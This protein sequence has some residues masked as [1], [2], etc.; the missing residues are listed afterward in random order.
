MEDLMSLE[1]VSSDFHLGDLRR[2]YDN[3]EASIRAL[4]ALGVAVETYGAL[5]TP[6]FMKKIPQDSRLTITRRVNSSDWNMKKIL[7]VFLEELEARERAIL[8][9]IRCDQPSQ[10]HHQRNFDRHPHLKSL[11]FTTDMGKVNEVSP[12]ILL[13]ADQYWSLLTGEVIKGPVAVKY[14]SEQ[15]TTMVTHVLRVKGLSKEKCLEKGIH[16]FWSV[17]SLGVVKSDYIEKVFLMIGIA[18]AD[19]DALRFLWYKDVAAKE[20][21]IQVY[22]FTRVVFGVGPSPYLL[23][24]TLAKHL[25]CF[26]STYPKSK[27]LFRQGGFNLRK[28]VSNCKELQQKIDSAE[29]TSGDIS[30]KPESAEDLVPT[31]CGVIGLAK[32]IRTPRCCLTIAGRNVMLVGFCHAFLKAYAEVIYALDERQKCMFVASKTPV[33]PLKKQTIPRLELLSALLL[34]RLIVS[35]K[36]SL[37]ELVSGCMCYKDS[38]IVI[39]S[40]EGTDKQW[41]QFVQNRV[42]EIRENVESSKWSHC[43]G[44]NNSADLPSRGLALKELSESSM[45][46]CGPL[47]LNDKKPGNSQLQ[48]GLPLECLDKLRMRER[49]V[50]FLSVGDGLS[51]GIMIGS[52]MEIERFSCFEKL[53]NTTVYILR[54]C[55][56]MKKSL[57]DG[58]GLLMETNLMEIKRKAEILWI[59]EV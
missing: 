42:R 47:W 59:Q 50:L 45:W 46:L 38:L 52:I 44:E 22:Q 24:A 1:S 55:D 10:C 36:Q 57:N 18:E 14:M 4:E 26:E 16:S 7:K 27:E 5:L 12:D 29:S 43:Q 35:V 8:P 6:I 37:S 19:Q 48:D 34:A 2:L 40:K 13:G 31:K 53:I 23:N 33:A 30:T 28:Y 21:E 51:T 11:E 3:T 41:K 15:S 56:R 49:E 25:K 54:F 20:P 32:P 9:K 39:H 58:S 17:E